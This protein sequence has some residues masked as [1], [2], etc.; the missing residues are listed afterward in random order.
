MILIFLITNTRACIGQVK[1]AQE[2]VPAF[3]LFRQTGERNFFCETG[4]F[5]CR[6]PIALRTGIE[7]NKT[8]WFT[9]ELANKFSRVSTQGT[10]RQMLYPT[11]VNAR[12]ENMVMSTDKEIDLILRQQGA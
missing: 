12:I 11:I 9:I 8:E 4:C 3:N 10:H 7:N 2:P 1:P 5:F 6:N